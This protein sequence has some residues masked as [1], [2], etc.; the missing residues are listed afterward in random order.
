MTP[1]SLSDA[2][3]TAMDAQNQRNL[4]DAE[5]G[6]ALPFRA[7]KGLVLI[8][9][10]HGT[11]SGRMD[12][13]RNVGAEVQ[14]GNLIV[15]KGR[16]MDPGLLEVPANL[17]NKREFEDTIGRISKKTIRWEST[18]KAAAEIGGA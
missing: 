11:L 6:Q 13:L 9:R 17:M 8:G 12:D 15:H 10:E 2:E 3:V 1:N 14:T 4:K 18:L 7:W 5:D 16:G